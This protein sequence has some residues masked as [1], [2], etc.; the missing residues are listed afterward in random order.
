MK[1]FPRDE[2]YIYHRNESRVSSS[3]KNS[4][5][6]GNFSR[7]PWVILDQSLYIS[8]YIFSNL[9]QGLKKRNRSIIDEQRFSTVFGFRSKLAETK[10]KT[11]GHRG[12][13]KLEEEEEEAVSRLGPRS[14]QREKATGGMKGGE[15]SE[16]KILFH[17]GARPAACTRRYP[18]TCREYILIR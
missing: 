16:K 17:S 7:L 2:K 8:I 5:D 10:R 18:H 6:V 15:R 13:L 14:R 4:I 1:T 3:A 11:L 9:C 12:R